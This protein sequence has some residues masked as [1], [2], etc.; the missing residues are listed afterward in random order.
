VGDPLFWLGLSLLLVAVS[1]TA[2]LVVAIPT[3]IELSR[4]A[5]SA[6]KL[7]D[8]LGKE[9]PPTLEAL[10]LTGLEITEL[11]ED[12]GDGI[13]H[14]GRIVQQV[15][16]SLTTARNQAKTL[17]AGSR[18]FWAGARAAWRT[19]SQS[20]QL[21][22]RGK[23]V[24][25]VRRRPDTDRRISP[26]PHADRPKLTPEATHRG[27][28]GSEL[29]GPQPQGEPSCSDSSPEP[30]THPPDPAEPPKP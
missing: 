17:Q 29:S 11:T 23:S 3:L 5:R 2:V 13:E 20:S 19:W 14:A 8:T 4:A 24:R 30:P 9:L 10:R 16:E 15:D 27:E 26:R 28:P 12:V 6:E 18:S 22:R 7:F 1:L 25:P 21:S